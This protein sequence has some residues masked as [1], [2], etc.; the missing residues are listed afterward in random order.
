MAEP[1]EFAAPGV[2]LLVRTLYALINLFTFIIYSLFQKCKRDF[3]L[4]FKE[5]PTRPVTGL[6][7]LNCG[8]V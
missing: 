2:R 5:L 4:F 1:R 3:A 6:I 8:L 7:N